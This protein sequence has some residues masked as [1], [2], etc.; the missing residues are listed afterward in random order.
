M[1]NIVQQLFLNEADL[2]EN[3]G[4]KMAKY[5]NAIIFAIQNCI[6]DHEVS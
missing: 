2:A 3:H 6:I 5:A 4:S 1:L